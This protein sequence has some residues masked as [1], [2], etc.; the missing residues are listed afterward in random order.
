MTSKIFPK[1]IYYGFTFLLGIF[2]VFAMLFFS[3][4]DVVPLK[5][6]EHLKAGEYREAILPIVN[7]FNA[8][9]VVEQHFDNGSVI[10]YEAVRFGEDEDGK[11]DRT[12]LCVMYAGFLY[13]AKDYE[14]SFDEDSKSALL[15]DGRT[16]A[17]SDYNVS[18]KRDARAIYFELSTSLETISEIEFVDKN[19]DSYVKIKDANLKFDGKFFADAAPLIERYNEDNTANEELQRLREEFLSQSDSYAMGSDA[20]A[21]KIVD[22]RTAIVVV[23]YF[24]CVYVLADFLFGNYYII[25]FFRW[26]IYDVCKAKSKNKQKPKDEIFG[27]D[28]YCQVTMSLDLEAVPDFCESVQVRYTNSDEEIAFILLKENDYTATNRIKAGVY[29]N[30]FIDMNRDYAP[31]NLPDNL[32]VEGYRMNVKIKI[33][34]REV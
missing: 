8:E 25:K 24:V 17:M 21:R 1:I 16:V 14:V 11:E 2:L 20:E 5:V 13:D 4:Y 12:V 28:Y 33:I 9:L 7:Y 22:I 29:V 18:G 23:V 27:R 30:P 26:F 6:V 15:V 34:K 10:I 31:V 19:G 32:E 3:M